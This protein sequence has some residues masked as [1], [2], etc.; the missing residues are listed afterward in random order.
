MLI[1]RADRDEF[2]TI[3]YKAFSSLRIDSS[4]SMFLFQRSFCLAITF[5][6]LESRAS[7]KAY[8]ATSLGFLFR[9]LSIVSAI[10]QA[11]AENANQAT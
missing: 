5:L 2:Q 8:S 6:G 11:G 7:S 10:D 3:I 1:W 4:W 9:P